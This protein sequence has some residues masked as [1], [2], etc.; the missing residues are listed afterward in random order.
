MSDKE[1]RTGVV[2]EDQGFYDYDYFNLAIYRC[3]AASE[4]TEEKLCA[5][6]TAYFGKG[7]PVQDL[8]DIFCLPEV[9]INLLIAPPSEFEKGMWPIAEKDR[10]KDNK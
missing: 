9:V 2:A 7:I 5:V 3:D 1:S 6:Q 4:I 10:R 8:V